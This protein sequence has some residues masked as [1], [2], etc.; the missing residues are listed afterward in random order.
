MAYTV[1]GKKCHEREFKG[2]IL[3]KPCEEWHQ[4][5]SQ[6]GVRGKPEQ[7]QQKQQKKKS[8]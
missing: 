4:F 5:A 6:H 3:E 7:Q 2:D 8:K 1:N